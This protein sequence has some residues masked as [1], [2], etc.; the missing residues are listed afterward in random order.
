VPTQPFT[1]HGP[2]V[3]PLFTLKAG[4][5]TFQVRNQGGGYFGVSVLDS[6]GKTVDLIANSTDVNFTGSKAIRIPAVGAYLVAVDSDG[7]W[8]VSVSQ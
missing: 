5:A 1:G 2:N 6:Q 8:T 4:L 7:D 3:T